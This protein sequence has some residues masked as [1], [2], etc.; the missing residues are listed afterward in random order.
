[1]HLHYEAGIKMERTFLTILNGNLNQIENG[2]RMN[3][4]FPFLACAS[5][6]HVRTELAS[7]VCLD[8]SR[9]KRYKYVP[10]TPALKRRL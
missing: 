2:A 7:H 1:M 10:E 8:D 6:I 9:R 5:F 4:I 3:Y